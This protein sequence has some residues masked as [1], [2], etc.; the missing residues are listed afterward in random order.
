MWVWE[1]VCVV[2]EWVYSSALWHR[3]HKHSF[4]TEFIAFP[5]SLSFCDLPNLY[6]FEEML[7]ITLAVI[8]HSYFFFFF[9]ASFCT[10][11][12]LSDSNPNE[13]Y[14]T[15]QCRCTFLPSG[16]VL[17]AVVVVVEFF[18]MFGPQCWQ[19]FVTCLGLLAFVDVLLSFC[20]EVL[21]V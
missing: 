1:C 3:K 9:F 21:V 20:C 11:Q 2:C 5:R 12:Q 7:K 17:L 15:Q 4:V 6:S 18:K 8:F 16:K 13:A 19:L 14:W 10:W